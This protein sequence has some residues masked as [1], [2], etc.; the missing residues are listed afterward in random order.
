MFKRTSFFRTVLCEQF[1]SQTGCGLMIPVDDI[2]PAAWGAAGHSVSFHLAI[3]LEFKK[4]NVWNQRLTF[5]LSIHMTKKKQASWIRSV[6]EPGAWW[7]ELHLLSRQWQ[8]CFIPWGPLTRVT[9]VAAPVI[10]GVER[11]RC[12]LYVSACSAVSRSAVC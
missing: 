8:V 1:R 4:N 5:S 3:A 9:G 7:G 10:V 6:Q 11:S 2:V 12:V